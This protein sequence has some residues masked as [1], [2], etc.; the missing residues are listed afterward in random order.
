AA[1]HERYL[2][3][4]AGHRDVTVVV[5]NQI[6][7]LPAGAVDRCLAD[8]RRLLDDDGLAGVPVLGVS[9]RTGA[10]LADL[11]ALLAERVADRASWSAR[12]AADVTTAANHLVTASAT[13]PRTEKTTLVPRVPAGGGDVPTALP[14][15]DGQVAG[16]EGPLVKALSR[17][18]GV[19]IVV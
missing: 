18:A 7:R 3:P 19:P 8:L 11:R 9:A 1:V 10:G 15:I 16:L 12:L 2:R 4:L 5:L 6:D 14:A 13:P 17:A